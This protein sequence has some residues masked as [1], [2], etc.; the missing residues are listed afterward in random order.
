MKRLTPYATR[1]GSLAGLALANLSVL[2]VEVSAL[3]MAAGLAMI[4]VLPGWAWLS[5][6]RWLGIRCALERVVLL[7]TLSA[8]ISALALLGAVYWPGPFD[9]AATLVS[10]D[11]AILAGVALRLLRGQAGSK[12]ETGDHGPFWP[13]ARVGLA[14]LAILT[15]AAFLRGYTIGY[16][17]FH[18]DEVE[19]LRLA[20][21][22]MKGEEYAPFLDSKGP[23]HWLLPGAV[24]LMHGWLNE[25][26][27]RAPFAIA[28]LL[29]V[30]AVYVLGRRIAGDGAGLAASGLV[31]INGFF[32]AY[33]RHIENPSLIVL[34]ATVA[35]WCL[36]RFYQKRE[37][38]ASD[39]ATG[40]LLVLVGLFL[41]VGLIAH[42]D[43]ILHVVPAGLILLFLFWRSRA[44]RRYRLWLLAAAGLFL[45]LTVAFYIPFVNDPYFQHTREY[46]AGERIGSRLLYN[47]VADMLELDGLY[48]TRY[49]APLLLLFSGIPLIGALCRGGRWGTALAALLV[50]AMLSTVYGPGLW[51]WGNVNGAI[52]PY[53]LFFAALLFYARIPLPVKGLVGWFAVPFLAMEFFAKDAADHVQIAYP[54]W[55]L[56]AGLGAQTFWGHLTGRLAI[57]LKVATALVLAGCL[58][59]LL[60]Y[61]HLQFLGTVADYWQAE[62]DSKYNERSVYRLLYGGLP[63]PRKLFSNPRLG[64]WKVV[65]YLYETGQLKGDFRSS[66]E[67]FAVPIWYTYQTPRSCFEDPQNYFLAVTARGE[68]EMMHAMPGM[69]YGLRRVVRVDGQP[70]LY[71]FEKGAPNAASPQVYNLDDYTAWFDRSATPQRYTQEALP[72]IPLQVTFGEQQLLL[73]GYDVSTTRLRPGD[74]LAV[75]LYWQARAPLNVRYRAFVHVE[76]DRLWGQHDDDPV[77]RLRS[78]EWR[79]PQFGM[80]QFRVRLDPATPPGSYPV[81]VG[82]YNPDTS[83]RLT[84][85]DAS[86]RMLGTAVELTTIMVE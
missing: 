22:A 62:A 81:T 73:R 74:T 49:Y 45:G 28:S 40:W 69:G 37:R 4:F 7:G 43:V 1:W 57:P 61:Q 30:L 58:G 79:P 19:N 59:L 27:G 78:D 76:S 80:G 6:T 8:A 23:V 17:E 25:A 56:L 33:A 68:P 48:S 63:R 12:A 5:A 70:R 31:A 84:A 36:Y 16:G 9:L 14:L 64:G 51:E 65:G 86:G 53:L 2:T 11:L 44:V 18:E 75:N 77:C 52:L 60:Y 67:S 66:K 3:R 26:V 41:G 71:L 72:P 29:T 46:L 10:L 50:A 20:V 34:W 82:L 54:A 21:R 15:L 47:Q 38:E 83:E 24:W 85:Y 13:S 32:V 55:C 42:P 35:A 39:S